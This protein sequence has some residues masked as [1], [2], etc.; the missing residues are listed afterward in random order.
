MGK[1]K[2]ILTQNDLLT[3][4]AALEQLGANLSLHVNSSLS[5]AHGVNVEQTNYY[6]SGGDQFGEAS[7][8]FEFGVP[9]NTIRLFAPLQLTALGP[10]STGNG[11]L[12]ATTPSGTLTSP[13][14][15]LANK[16][17]VTELASPSVDQASIYE[18]ILLAHANSVHSDTGA[19]Q[20]HGGQTYTVS[21]VLDSL[22]HTVGRRY[23]TLGVNGIAYRIPCDEIKTG[24]PQPPRF[25]T[26]TQNPD[27]G[28]SFLSAGY[29]QHDQYRTGDLTY[30]DLYPLGLVWTALAQSILPITYQWFY[31]PTPSFVSNPTPP[32]INDIQWTPWPA[33]GNSSIVPPTGFYWTTV[34]PIYNLLGTGTSGNYSDMTTWFKVVATNTAGTASM[35]LRFRTHE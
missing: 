4:N 32:A 8:V 21:G 6:D 7:V 23:I 16:P 11:L 13:G 31:Y 15:P 35:L 5:T 9:P 28:F 14:V 10:A 19:T 1:I 18:N 27:Y 2:G 25:L 20:V 12:T 24:P 26:I 29:Y 17:L 30:S 33:S 34:G 3:L 22:G